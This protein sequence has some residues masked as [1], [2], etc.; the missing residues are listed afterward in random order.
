MTTQD[1]NLIGAVALNILA[2]TL[3]VIAIRQR[4]PVRSVWLYTALATAWGI[5][6]VTAFAGWL[7]VNDR[8]GEFGD[9]GLFVAVLRGFGLIFMLTLVIHEMR[10]V[11]K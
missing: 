9:L 10:H 7:I 4:Y 1:Y 11:R 5:G 8:R 6:V 3:F 2:I